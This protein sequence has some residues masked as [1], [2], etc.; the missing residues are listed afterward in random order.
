MD[1]QRFHNFGTRPL[2]VTL[3]ISVDSAAASQIADSL[4][5]VIERAIRQVAGAGTV[6]KDSIAPAVPGPLPPGAAEPLLIRSRQAAKLLGISERTLWSLRNSEKAPRPIQFGNAVR[7]NLEELWGWVAA[8]CP[9]R[10]EW[11]KMSNSR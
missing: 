3:T 11:E 8:G 10:A 1:A 7:W 4:E 6:R 5:K 9:G 2:Q